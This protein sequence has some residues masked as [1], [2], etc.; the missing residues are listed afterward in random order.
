[1]SAGKAAVTGGLLLGASATSAT[2]PAVPIL[3][4]PLWVGALGDTVTIITPQHMIAAL[5]GVLGIAVLGRKLFSKNRQ[6]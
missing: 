2:V 5:T 1:M 6:E 3:D 4:Y